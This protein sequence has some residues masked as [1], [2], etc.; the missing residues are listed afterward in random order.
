MFG[1]GKPKAQPP[2]A[3]FLSDYGYSLVGL[4]NAQH[5]GF[6]EEHYFSAPSP[7]LI[8]QCLAED[9]NKHYLV[10]HSCQVILA[11]NLYQLILMDMPDVAEDEIAKAL[12][13]QLKGLIDYPLN[14]IAVD[15]F[16]VPPHGAGG[17]R[18]KTFVTVTLLSA[19]INKVAMLE[20][21]LLNVASISI[22]ELALSKILTRYPL[23]SDAPSIVISYD[24]ELCQL[25]VH[26][27]HD[28]YLF[29]TLPMSPS[30]IQ[31]D[32]SANQ[33]MLLEIQRSIDYCLIELKLPEPKQIFFTPSFYEAKNLLI[34]LQ[35][36][37]DKD[38]R[39]LDINLLFASEP[40]APEIMSKIFYAVGGA[41]MFLNGSN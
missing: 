17:K 30:I 25:H 39:L 7:L 18:K 4:E 35:K 14:D 5:I 41:L 3:C 13:W 19:L 33:D 36:E 29:R 16:T 9:V 11:P 8:A 6:Y 27:Q 38:V 26:Y 23:L 40:I 21:C 22:S 12:R 20:S 28:L 37:L 31:A 24:E 1:I 10:G 15:A 32:S 34:F 2:L